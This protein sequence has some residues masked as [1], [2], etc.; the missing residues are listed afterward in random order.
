MVVKLVIYPSINNPEI[1]STPSVSYPK[2]LTKTRHTLDDLLSKA[3]E[4]ADSYDPA[5]SPN[6]PHGM[7]P[8]DCDVGDGRVAVYRTVSGNFA[9]EDSQTPE[10]EFLDELVS[11][12]RRFGHDM[13]SFAVNCASGHK[14][15][16]IYHANEAQKLASSARVADIPSE[17]KKNITDMYDLATI[18]NMVDFITHVAA[19]IPDQLHG[20]DFGP[21]SDSDPYF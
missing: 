2:G 15:T 16:A 10:V 20:F 6:D 5:F 12:I 21:D 1:M 14:E 3:I 17:A 18:L 7:G 9:R 19:K 11:T 4:I 13:G 8:L